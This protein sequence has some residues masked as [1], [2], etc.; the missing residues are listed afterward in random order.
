MLMRNFF[1]LFPIRSAAW[2]AEAAAASSADAAKKNEE[3]ELLT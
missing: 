3:D 1:H 2:K